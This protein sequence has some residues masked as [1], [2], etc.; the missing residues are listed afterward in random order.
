MSG[1][2][3]NA[4]AIWKSWGN[5][6]INV[7]KAELVSPEGKNSKGTSPVAG[8]EISTAGSAASA[9]STGIAV[10]PAAVNFSA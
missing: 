6:R 1:E 8:G 3:C 10:S 2:R 9:S 4:R 5:L 7:R